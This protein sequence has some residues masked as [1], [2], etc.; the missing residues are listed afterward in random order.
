MGEII[1][2]FEVIFSLK[3]QEV[4]RYQLGVE[5]P[6]DVESGIVYALRTFRIDKPE[7]DLLGDSLYIQVQ[8]ADR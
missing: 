3:G 6:A 1:M 8:R 2:N 4:A 5:T 7:I